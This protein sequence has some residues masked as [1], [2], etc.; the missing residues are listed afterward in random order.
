V[1]TRFPFRFER[2]LVPFS[3]AFGVT[4]RTAWV[5]VDDEDLRVRFGPWR[6]VTPRRN[7]VDGQLTG[8]YSFAKVAG[9]AH[10]SFADRGVTFATT[11]ERGVCFT[12]REPVPGIAPFG[13]LPHP[14]VT[15]TVAD[16]E[17][18]LEVAPLP[19]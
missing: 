12:L 5:E 13:R 6:L 2:R 15:V 9:P 14:G 3:L 4:P 18:L 7:I 8:P 17:R 10:L 16:P 19:G 1:A 11:T